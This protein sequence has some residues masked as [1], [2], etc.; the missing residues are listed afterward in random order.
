MLAS[1][2]SSDDE[3]DG[4]EYRIFLVH[5]NDYRIIDTWNA[6]GLRG[7]GSNDVE[8]R[9]AFVA[10]P[11]TVA[12]Q[13][14]RRRPDAGKR[15]QSECAV[16][17]AGVLA[18]SLCA[19]R[20]RA[21]QRAGLPRRLCR[22]RPASRLDLQPR[23]ARRPPEH[24]DQDRRSLRQDRRRAPDHALDLYRG[25]GRRTTRPYSGHGRQDQIAARRG[26]FRQ[27]LHRSGV[28]AVCGERR[29][30]LVHDRRACSGSFAMPTRSI[31]TSRSIS[32]RRAPITVGSR[33]ACRPKT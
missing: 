29:A 20:R 15:R 11:M 12:V 18:V 13:R 14:S 10:E 4:I 21:R 6:A 8:V 19:F 3:A 26:L 27:S 22:S 2:V 32:M 33:L 9:D 24:A 28:A 16:Y 25:D 17:A 30:G 31:R 7:T 23:Q 5:K 1:V